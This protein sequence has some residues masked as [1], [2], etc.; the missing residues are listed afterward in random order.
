MKKHHILILILSISSFSHAQDVEEVVTSALADP[1]QIENPLHLVKSVDLEAEP[2]TSLGEALDNLAGVG[3]AD[4]GAAIGQPIIRGLSGARI[5]VL[6]NGLVVRDVAGIGADHPNDI[7]L[8]NATQVEVVRGPSSLL[9]ANG[10]I[11]GIINIVD[12]SIAKTDFDGFSGSLGYE[13]QEVNDGSVS[14]YNFQ[15]NVAG[16]NFSLSGLD[17]DFE[18]YV[19]P[20]GSVIEDGMKTDESIVMNSDSAAETGKFGVSKTGD[21]GYIGMSLS[22]A[23]RVHGIPFHGEEHGEHDEHHDDDHETMDE[24]EHEG[25]EHDEHE[26]ERIFAMTESDIFTLQGSLNLGNGL[27]NKVDYFLTT[28]EYSLMEQHAE[29]HGEEHH[30]DEEHEGEDH[31]GEDHDEHEGHSEE[32]TLFTNDATEFGMIFDLSNDTVS[33]THLTLPTKA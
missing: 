32:P 18:N 13:M 3:S 1:S 8:S 27:V 12:N 21:W 22:S 9:Y 7:D 4:Y 11:G 5:K 6:N 28:S 2:T 14:T 16:L 26:G 24:D 20:R 23:E 15:H 17:S 31:E 25:E 19:T 29:E 30:D 10:T 33:Y